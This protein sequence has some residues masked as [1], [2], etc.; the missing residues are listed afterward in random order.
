MERDGLV[1]ALLWLAEQD[2]HDEKREE[3]LDSESSQ[4]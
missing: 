1:E 2:V 4:L 3:P